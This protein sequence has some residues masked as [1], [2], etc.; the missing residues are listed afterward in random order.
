M[1]IANPVAALVAIALLGGCNT[2]R[3]MANQMVG[4]LEAS[5]RAFARE[6]SPE[7][8]RAAA[9]ASLSM[10][11]GFIESAPHN[12]DL[13]RIAAEMNANAAFALIEPRE[14]FGWVMPGYEVDA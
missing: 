11:D 10:L 2:T 13:L 4:S 3:F 1:R 8:A 6:R 12:E 9:P 5:K 7:Q 14:E